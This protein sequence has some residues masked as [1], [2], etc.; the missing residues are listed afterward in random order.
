MDAADFEVG[1]E[2]MK[3]ASLAM[4]DEHNGQFG[5]GYRQ[6]LLR[7]RERTTESLPEH[8]KLA[9]RVTFGLP[10]TDQANGECSEMVIG[11]RFE[12][13]R[14]IE[15]AGFRDD[16]CKAGIGGRDMHGRLSDS[17]CE[18]GHHPFKSGVR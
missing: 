7:R 2:V 5:S 15:R 14:Q 10:L 1:G 3:I 16:R 18:F 6:N 8:R 4:A 12:P 11:G 13:P 17:V 9:D